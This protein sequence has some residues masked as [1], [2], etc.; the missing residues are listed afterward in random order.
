MHHEWESGTQVE[1]FHQQKYDDIPSSEHE[2]PIL[3]KCKPVLPPLKP[4]EFERSRIMEAYD[5]ANV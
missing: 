5:A 4:F 2:M 1:N 3:T